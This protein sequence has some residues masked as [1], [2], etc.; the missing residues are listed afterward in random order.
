[1]KDSVNDLM[2]NQSGK[3]NNRENIVLSSLSIHII[4]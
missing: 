2:H 4:N 1:M 3:K